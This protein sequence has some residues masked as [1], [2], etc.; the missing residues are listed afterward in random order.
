MQLTLEQ[1]AA[2]LGKSP[3]QVRY[4]IEQGKLPA[5]K[6]EGRWRI[7]SEALP[8]A[9][10][11][12][13]A[14][15]TAGKRRKERLREVVDEALDLEGGPERRYSVLDLKAFQVALPLY[16]RSLEALGEEHPASGRLRTVL[17]RLALGCHRFEPKDKTSAYRE[18]W[19]A[20]SLAVCEL[21][22]AGGEQADT[23]R[24]ALEQDLMAAL[25]GLLR[26]MD[27]Q[28]RR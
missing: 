20:A 18:A 13:N 21:V 14:R 17:E 2:A 27:R 11:R 4:M 15:Q 12:E 22:L 5:E 16:R 24:Q 26:R 9:P 23:L 10:A 19:D 7:D 8:Q 3:R 1:A 25:A 28:R 6:V